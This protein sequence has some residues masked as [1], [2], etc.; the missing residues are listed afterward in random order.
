MQFGPPIP[1]RCPGSAWIAPTAAGALALRCIK[2][3]IEERLF[4]RCRDLFSALSLVSWF[5]GHNQLWSFYGARRA[6]APRTSSLDDTA[7]RA[8]PCES[9]P[10]DQGLL[11]DRGPAVLA[12]ID[13]RVLST[14][15]QQ[16]ID[17]IG[18]TPSIQVE[19][20]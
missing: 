11:S 14:E 20:R 8:P 17:E 3:P 12:G 19:R 7:R 6:T 4:E 5:H 2:D 13:A 16:I 15:L 1:G 9:P 18:L 10:R